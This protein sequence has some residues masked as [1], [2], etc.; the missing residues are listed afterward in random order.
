MISDTKI[1]IFLHNSAEINVFKF[2]KFGSSGVQTFECSRQTGSGVSLR[3]ELTSELLNSRT[4]EQQ[5]EAKLPKLELKIVGV[6]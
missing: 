6:R 2:R 1:R 4:L 5:K 3:A